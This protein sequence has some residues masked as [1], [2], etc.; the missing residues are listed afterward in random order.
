MYGLIFENLRQ[1]IIAVYG[2]DKWEEIRRQARVEHPSFTTHDIYPD[3][4][5]LRIVGKGCKVQGSVQGCSMLRMSYNVSSPGPP[6]LLRRP[7][8]CWLKLC[9]PFP[10]VLR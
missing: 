1:Y 9:P 8:R 10:F 5:I 6:P 4:V 3:S 2:E 7:S